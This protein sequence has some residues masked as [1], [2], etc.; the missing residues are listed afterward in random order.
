LSFDE[1]TEIMAQ[2]LSEKE[3]KKAA[4][5]ETTHETE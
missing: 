4:E 5:K 1:I 3:A 2:G